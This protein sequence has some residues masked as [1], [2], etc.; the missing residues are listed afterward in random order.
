M[1][2]FALAADDGQ[3]TLY[4]STWTKL[5]SIATAGPI[6]ALAWAPDGHLLAVGHADGALAI[7]HV[8]NGE[9]LATVTHHAV[10][11]RRILWV[12]ATE[13]A[14]ARDSPYATPIHDLFAPLPPL[15]SG[16][17]A[18]QMLLDA[19]QPQ[20]DERL[21]RLL[22]QPDTTFQFDIVVSADA[23]ARVHLAVDGRFSLG[24][25]ALNEFPSLS[26]GGEPPALLK[27]GLSPTLRVLTAIVRTARPTTVSLSDGTREQYGP[28]ALVLAFRT[29]QLSRARLEI[30][31]LARAYMRASALAE[32]VA[33]AVA[34]ARTLWEEA[35]SPLWEK[36]GQLAHEVKLESGERGL[37]RELLN[38]HAFG[39]PSAALH[40]SLVR[41]FREAELSR[42]LKATGNAASALVQLC[43]T[44]LHPALE[45]LI[46]L[47]GHLLGLSR[48]PHHFAVTLG[49]QPARVSAVLASAASM[50]ASSE[51]LLVS[52][53]DFDAGLGAFI[54]WFIRA[55]R[56][57]RDEA[58]PSADEFP[59]PDCRA[60]T[61]Y[62][63]AAPGEDGLPVDVLG[64]L[65]AERDG[66]LAATNAPV[67]DVLD[68]VSELPPTRRLPQ[69]QS[70]LTAA[71]VECF[72][73]VAHHISAG[74]QLHS[75]TPLYANS[76]AVVAAQQAGSEAL[77]S[78][79]EAL[80]T[81]DAAHLAQPPP[82]ADR[83]L[84]GSK[85]TPLLI[86]ALVGSDN[87]E[88]ASTGVHAVFLR[89]VC[90]LHD[91][92]RPDWEACAVH[93]PLGAPLAALLYQRDAGRVLL[94]HA[95]ANGGG[96]ALSLSEYEGLPFRLLAAGTEPLVDR[97][98]S[99]A[100]AGELPLIQLAHDKSRRFANTLPAH[101]ALSHRRGLASLVSTAG[102]IYLLDLEGE[103]EEEGESDEA[104]DGEDSEA[105]ALASVSEHGGGGAAVVAAGD[106]AVG[107][108]GAG[109]G[110]ASEGMESD[111]SDMALE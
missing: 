108:A 5:Y 23:D 57:V 67:R 72:E 21:Y 91:T 4:R 94:L 46:H 10:E 87:G 97:A 53:R 7:Y 48:W 35:V 88:V 75:C 9:L 103:G 49:L 2:L 56:K 22:F 52:A 77:C 93:A 27:L 61:A 55:G 71:I 37:T 64:D 90:A 111:E 62:L 51:L 50:R 84:A 32:R 76:P 8:E 109:S 30:E 106:S 18:Q 29:G 17:S 65:L 15:P 81:I 101:M 68:D 1:D 28:G 73:P 44:Q 34:L 31:A 92:E 20:L 47:S 45:I 99:A 89:T 63:S 40:A 19:L 33:G 110:C 14:A 26:F 82:L 86:L 78:V 104:G 58:P 100:R 59:L 39:V 6:H 80:C 42:A 24:Y 74:F 60:V 12:R 11:L 43:V 25:L 13:A 107:G 70:A 38:L 83:S 16:P 66:P 3:L 98:V 95:L 105:M 102:R 79:E 36:L 96:S 54:G 69:L 41:D 85:S